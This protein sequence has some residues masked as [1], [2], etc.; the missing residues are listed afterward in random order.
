MIEAE[1]RSRCA[2]RWL[3]LARIAALLVASAA[4]APQ[5]VAASLAPDGVALTVGDGNDVTVYGIATHWDSLCTCPALRD[6]GFDTRLVAQ[7]A[8]W[9]GREQP[10][11]RSSLWDLGITPVLRWIGPQAAARWFFEVGVGVH[12]LS[13]TRINTERVF[14]TAFQF[15]EIAGVGMAFGEHRRYEVGVYIQHVS[16][17][18]I[19]EPN[20]GLTYFG[21]AARVALP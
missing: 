6:R 7:A 14:S 17:G 10:A 3:T 2:R 8:Y 18:G 5:A 16:N 21:A 4:A 13:A 11:E 12:L 9:H 15:G 20:D 19:K 1:H